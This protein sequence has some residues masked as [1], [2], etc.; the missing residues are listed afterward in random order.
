MF[1]LSAIDISKYRGSPRHILLFIVFTKITLLA[2]THSINTGPVD[3]TLE[4]HSGQYKLGQRIFT[5]QSCGEGGEHETS[6][7]DRIDMITEHD[8][9]GKQKDRNQDTKNGDKPDPPLK[10]STPSKVVAG[11][12]TAN[13]RHK[14]L[15]QRR[16]TDPHKHLRRDTQRTRVGEKKKNEHGTSH[17]KIEPSE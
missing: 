16:D 15:H 1:V 7:G 12:K 14:N 5:K 11:E 2:L 10:T 6:S 17:S 3:H 4:T 9:S 8:H 13:T